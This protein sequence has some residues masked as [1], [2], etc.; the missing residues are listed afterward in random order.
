MSQHLVRKF[1]KNRW[2]DALKTK[3]PR[4]F[5]HRGFGKQSKLFTLYFP[6]PPLSYSIANVAGVPL[7]CER[8]HTHPLLSGRCLFN[9]LDMFNV[10]I[11]EIILH[12]LIKVKRK[13]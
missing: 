11:V 3:K 12:L 7:N 1:L 2:D 10:F 8:E 13:F 9:D 5:H 4:D 6:K